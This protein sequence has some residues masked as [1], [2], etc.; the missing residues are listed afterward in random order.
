MKIL[1]LNSGPA[2]RKSASTNWATTLPNNPPCCLWEAKIE[3]DGELAET[4]IKTAD[5]VVQQAQVKVLSRAEA[6]QHLLGHL[7]SGKTKVLASPGD[8]DSVG[9][10]V[11]HGGPQYEEPLLITPEVKSVIASV[12]AFAPLHNRAELEGM[13]IVEKLLGSVPQVAVFDTGFHRKMPL[14]AAVYPGPV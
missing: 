9:H 13:A 1:A 7:W 12:S 2:A 4:V 14:A 10:R 3:W 6:V 5:G 11:V 8:I